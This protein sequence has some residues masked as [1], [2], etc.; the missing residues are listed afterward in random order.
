MSWGKALLWGNRY[1]RRRPRG[2][3]RRLL[4]NPKFP[5]WLNRLGPSLRGRL[6][7]VPAPGVGLRDSYFVLAFSVR[8]IPWPVLW[9][10][11]APW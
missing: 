1:R 2:I 4:I 7:P 5:V 6:I 3:R 8:N 10:P 9:R 11:Y